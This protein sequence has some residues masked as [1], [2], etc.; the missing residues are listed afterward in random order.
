M[1]SCSGKTPKSSVQWYVIEDK[2][3]CIYCKNY[4]CCS[5]FEIDS[6]KFQIFDSIPRTCD[7]DKV[8]Y[9]EN[10]IRCPSCLMLELPS[11]RELPKNYACRRCLTKTAWSAYCQNCSI[12]LVKCAECGNP[13]EAGSRYLST[14][15]VESLHLSKYVGKLINNEVNPMTE[16]CSALKSRTD[17]LFKLCENTDSEQ[18][19]LK[20]LRFDKIP[21]PEPDL[22]SSSK[23]PNWNCLIL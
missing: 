4:G 11:N 21:I 16:W 19:R 1:A 18:L 6:R 22:N 2:S 10:A 15:Q 5:D 8:H 9:A 20:L 3:Y 13:I 14:L 23:Y 7:C 17:E 12:R